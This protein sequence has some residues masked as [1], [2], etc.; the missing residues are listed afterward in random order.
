[1]PIGDAVHY[2]SGGTTLCSFWDK[3][4]RP[5]MLLSS[6]HGGQQNKRHRDEGKPDI[7]EFYNCTKSGVDNLDKLIRGYNS[8]HKCRRWSPAVYWQNFSNCVGTIA[9]LLILVLM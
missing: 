8:K 5:V 6:M 7:V 3:D 9:N 2:Y 1:M 4:T